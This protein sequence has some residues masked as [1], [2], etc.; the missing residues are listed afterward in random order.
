[1]Y[2]YR[3]TMIG[4]QSNVVQDVRITKSGNEYQNV[5]LLNGEGRECEK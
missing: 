2:V 5:S 1:M 4:L 3:L